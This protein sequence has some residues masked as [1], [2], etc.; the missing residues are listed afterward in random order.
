MQKSMDLGNDLVYD[1]SSYMNK[2]ILGMS[3]VDVNVNVVDKRALC[4]AW[5]MAEPPSC[6]YILTHYV[7]I[8]VGNEFQCRE[9]LK[10]DGW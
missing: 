6:E 7:I 3:N 4:V 2:S 10:S 5:C 1:V 9:K 8:L